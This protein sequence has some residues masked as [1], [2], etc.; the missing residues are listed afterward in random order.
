MMATVDHVLS[1][2]VVTAGAG[3]LAGTAT[4]QPLAAEA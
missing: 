1:Y 3:F 4:A 2:A